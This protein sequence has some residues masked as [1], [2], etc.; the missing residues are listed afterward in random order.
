VKIQPK[1]VMNFG[2][3]RIYSVGFGELLEIKEIE[4]YRFLFNDMD[5]LL[6]MVL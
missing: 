3:T 5:K 1:T 6:N 4:N 2:H